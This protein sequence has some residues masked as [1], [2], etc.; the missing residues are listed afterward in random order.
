MFTD[1]SSIIADDFKSSASAFS[2]YIKD[3]MIKDGTEFY[4]EGT[5]N[6]AEASAMLLGFNRINKMIKKVDKKFITLPV[7]VHVYS[8]SLNT[9]ESCRSWIYNWIKKAR[10]GVWY[11]SSGDI[12]ANQEILKDI[13]SKYLTN[14]MYILKFFHINS[15]KIDL[16]VYS[17]YMDEILYYFENRHKKS[18]LKLDIPEKIWENKKFLEAKETFYKKNKIKIEDIELLRLLIYNKYVDELADKCL[19]EN[20]E[21]LGLA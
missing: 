4:K 8:D 12:V 18:K 20:L 13:H 5:N 1:G 19:T 15:H 10:K 17:D 16:K 3:R 2:V 6:L 11:N 21:E 14:D 9:V 7:E